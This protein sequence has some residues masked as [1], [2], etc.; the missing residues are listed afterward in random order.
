M[1]S[2]SGC[3]TKEWIGSMPHKLKERLDAGPLLGPDNV[4]P[5]G[6][7]VDALATGNYVNLGIAIALPDG[8]IVPVIKDADHMVLCSPGSGG[9]RLIESNSPRGGSRP[10]CRAELCDEPDDVVRA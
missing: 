7:R 9:P 2:C 4:P 6:L 8:V 10:M 1:L 5:Q 3:R